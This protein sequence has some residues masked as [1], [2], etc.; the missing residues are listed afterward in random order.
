MGVL[1]H[2]DGFK[3]MATLRRTK[4]TLKQRFWTDI[5]EGCK[6]FYLSGL[7]HGRY[8]KHE[9]AN[10]AR[11]ISVMKFRPLIWRNSHPY[12][13]VDRMEDLT[14]PAALQRDPLMSRSICFFGFVRGT[15]LKP[16]MKVHVPGL[17]DYY[18]SEMTAIDDPCPLP[19]S[20][21]KRRLNAKEKRLYAPMSN[22]GDLT[23]DADA[24]YVEIPDAAVRF[25][26]RGSV[27]RRG[28]A[29]GS[30]ESEN[31]AGETKDNADDDDDDDDDDR[32]RHH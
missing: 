5:Y 18:M 9:T 10:L 29:E 25:T 13:L 32:R 27:G 24:V 17:G 22:L 19:E 3:S 26:A 6:L 1:T 30:D 11:F 14:P 12:V 23:Y 31:E 2:L 28:S 8:P 4:K 16:G 15:F 20:G 21:A 7:K